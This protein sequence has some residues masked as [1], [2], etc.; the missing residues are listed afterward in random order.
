MTRQPTRPDALRRILGGSPDAP[1]L[2]IERR[3]R[4]SPDDLWLALTDPERVER[5]LGKLVGPR[6]QRVGDPYRIETPADSGMA[7]GTILECR[8]PECL[9]ADWQ[10]ADEPASRLEITLTADPEAE[11]TTLLLQHRLQRADDVAGHGGGWE[12]RLD[13]LVRTVAPGDPVDEP[14]TAEKAGRQAW[15]RLA[16][17]QGEAHNN[18]RVDRV[19]P[20]PVDA[21]WSAFTTPA[22]IATWWWT[23]LGA[24]YEID[25]RIG[26]HY[27]FAAPAAGFAVRGTYLELTP[28]GHLAVSWIWEDGDVDGP[29][30]RV[31]VTLTAHPDGT[32]VEIHHRGPWE[33]PAQQEN[34]RLGWESTLD[35]LVSHHTA[36]PPTD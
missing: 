21:V 24:E 29:V 19:V 7:T 22:G 31:D 11:A 2:T 16:A 35:G 9:I 28:P 34:Y 17:L 1:V 18:V 23:R 5:W 30:E 3:Y 25:A 33:D 15:Q 13:S 32:L 20:A 26:G 27:R 12:E 6:P 4:T 14:A 36:T 8:P 10:W